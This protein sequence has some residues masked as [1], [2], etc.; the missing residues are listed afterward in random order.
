M[1]TLI[2]Y[3]R[4]SKGGFMNLAKNLENAAAIFPD[5]TAVIEG[6]LS[7]SYRALNANAD[8]IASS[9]KKTGIQ[10][11]DHVAL[12]VPN[13][14]FWIAAYFGVLKTGAVAVTLPW[15]MTRNEMAPVLDDCRPRFV[16]TDI[17]RKSEFETKDY[18]TSVF[19]KDSSESMAI[20]TQ[21]HETVEC[22]PDDTAAILYTGGTTGMPKGVMLTHRNIISS[23]FNVAYYER[24]NEDDLVLC[25]LP[26]NHVFA[27]VHIMNSTVLSAGGMVIQASFDMDAFLEAITTHGVT[28]LYSV[29]TVYT[30]LLSQD[31]LREKLGSVRYCFSA[32]VSLI[33][34]KSSSLLISI[35]LL[36][37]L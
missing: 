22:H 12:C 2:K 4:M 10:K 1:C 25:F 13:S 33:A 26:L 18:V 21:N 7:V 15:T 17:A 14:S 9:L 20:S 16:F 3:Q 6:S 31:N 32:A 5:R 19:L 11:G 28:K 35:H 34:D 30:R 23:A 29:P 24:S 37:S 27:Q 8:Q 36:F